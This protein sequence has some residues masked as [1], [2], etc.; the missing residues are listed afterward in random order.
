MKA[1]RRSLAEQETT[2]SVSRADE[3]VHVWSA[4]PAH[5]AAF[6]RDDRVR[7]VGV[8]EW[9]GVSFEI[10]VEA[11]HP[12]KGMRVRRRPLSPEAREAAVEKMRVLRAA[13]LRSPAPSE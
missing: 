3:V 6:R 8:D 9:G 7:E 1:Y 13:Q 10:P 5:I 4:D 2:I 11:W 12:T